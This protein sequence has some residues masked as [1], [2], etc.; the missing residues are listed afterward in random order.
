MQKTNASTTAG[1]KVDNSKLIN[2]SALIDGGAIVVRNAGLHVTDSSFFGCKASDWG[3]AISIEV[4]DFETTPQRA[5]PYVIEGSHFDDN[6]CQG[7]LGI[8]SGESTW[9]DYACAAVSVHTE[10]SAGLSTTSKPVSVEV[11]GSSFSGNKGG[12]GVGGLSVS[13]NG[14]AACPANDVVVHSTNFTDN[15][16][17][18]LVAYANLDVSDSNFI[19]NVQV[20][21]RACFRF[22]SPCASNQTIDNQVVF[23]LSCAPIRLRTGPP[24]IHRSFRRPSSNLTCPSHHSAEL[25]GRWGDPQPLFQAYRQA[26]HI[27]RQREH[28]RTSDHASSS[29]R[30]STED[31][32]R[33]HLPVEG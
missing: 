13:Q 26:L 5:V 12:Y 30:V 23:L 24:L 10:C 4:Y 20:S 31:G 22:W 7:A 33:R 9:E 16:G 2:C 27:R 11:T 19:G 21:V 18:I 14:S 32:R 8:P 25:M 1:L 3:T 28:R 15:Q 29:G 17:G 6:V